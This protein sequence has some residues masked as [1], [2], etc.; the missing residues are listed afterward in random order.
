VCGRVCRGVVGRVVGGVVGGVLGGVLGGVVGRGGDLRGV[1]GTDLGG[2][3]GVDER[4]VHGRQALGPL[5][6]AVQ[7]LVEHLVHPDPHAIG[8]HRVGPGP[9][10]RRRVVVDDQKPRVGVEQVRVEQ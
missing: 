5:R 3:H 7:H 10:V 1:R 4:Q 6:L 9:A 2:R 8:E